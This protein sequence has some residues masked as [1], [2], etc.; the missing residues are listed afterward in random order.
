[1]AEITNLESSLPISSV[2]ELAIQRPK[3]VP[4]RYIRDDHEIGAC[5]SDSSLRVPLIDMAKLVN[6]ETRAQELQTLHL[7][8]THWGLFQVLQILCFIGLIF[9]EVIVFVLPCSPFCMW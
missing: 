4:P 9:S 3:Q 2:Q 1:M 8:C 5:P 6:T 7:A